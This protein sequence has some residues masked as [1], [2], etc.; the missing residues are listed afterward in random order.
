MRSLFNGK[1]ARVIT[2]AGIYAV[3]LLL[4]TAGC[5]GPSVQHA[6]KAAFLDVPFVKQEKWYCGAA[7]VS[8]NSRYHGT[9]VTQHQIAESLFSKK[10]GG[11][12]NIHITMLL[13]EM[14]FWTRTLSLS[15][16]SSGK[17]KQKQISALAAEIKTYIDRE[18]PVIAL[19]GPASGS[20]FGIKFRI[21]LGPLF[22]MS[23]YE[24]LTN[25]NHYIIL[26]GYDDSTGEFIAHNGI[27]P[28]VRIP[29]TLF[30]RRWEKTGCWALVAVPPS[31][32]NW[33]MTAEEM[34]DSGYIFEQTEKYGK[35]LECYTAALKK[36]ES[37]KETP[38]KEELRFRIRFNTAN[39]YFSLNMF[40]KAENILKDLQTYTGETGPLLNNLAEV[41]LRTDR[42]LN[43]A[44]AMVVK[45][46]SKDKDN[47]IYYFDT[48]A[49]ILLKQGVMDKARTILE[50]AISSARDRNVLSVLHYHM[51][52][53]CEARN[54]FQEA[55]YHFG[56]AADNVNEEMK[57]KKECEY[58]L[59]RALCG[60]KIGKK[61]QAVMGLYKVIALDRGKLSREARDNLLS[62]QIKQAEKSSGFHKKN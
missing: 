9:F 34:L 28:N 57:P 53:L 31:Q 45:A 4:C 12:L 59:R 20:V 23:D 3:S 48:L 24:E 26:V 60:L 2:A 22:Y 40:D 19:V 29:Y 58:T 47:R 30:L 46:I 14:G 1:T 54:E 15:D 55:F 39:T 38:E 10:R 16:Y 33:E 41:Y 43:K 13:R 35:A 11:I 50:Q 36:T 7:A 8:S 18:H 25:L 61:D 37:M 6:T 49:M 56:R 51:G 27:K 44:H 52:M 32:I 5:G 21:F 17:A 62:I 42:D